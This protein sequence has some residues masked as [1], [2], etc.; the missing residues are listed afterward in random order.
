MTGC[1]FYLMECQS[2]FGLSLAQPVDR[3]VDSTDT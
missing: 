1:C 3:I 2:D